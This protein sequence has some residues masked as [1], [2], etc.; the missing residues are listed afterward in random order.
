MVKGGAQ[1]CPCCWGASPGQPAP[2]LGGLSWRKRGAKEEM[3]ERRCPRPA[4]VGSSRQRRRE[5]F[6]SPEAAGTCRGC[7]LHLASTLRGSLG[8]SPGPC[9]VPWSFPVH[10]DELLRGFDHHYTKG[11]LNVFLRTLFPTA[12]SSGSNASL[13]GPGWSRS[14]PVG[15]HN[16]LPKP[17][18]PWKI[19]PAVCVGK[20]SC[21]KQNTAFPALMPH[22][23]PL[24]TQTI[25]PAPWHCLC[26]RANSSPSRNHSRGPYFSIY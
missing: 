13:A 1:V 7:E 16:P 2:G 20:E 4:P 5:D 23:R 15:K 25:G 21:R 8:C 11:F 10:P 17:H 14:Y 19:K 22:R 12:E 26:I 6:L 3:K 9:W 24:N 18:F